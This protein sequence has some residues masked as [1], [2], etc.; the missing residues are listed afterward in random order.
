MVPSGSDESD[1]EDDDSGN[2]INIVPP[3]VRQ[4][5]P[6]RSR[7]ATL[8]KIAASQADAATEDAEDEYVLRKAAHESGESE[9]D[10][11][12]WEMGDA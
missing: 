4:K 2:G 12:E 3:P 7:G 1:D 10:D 5:N 9:N 8:Q 6:D 11:P